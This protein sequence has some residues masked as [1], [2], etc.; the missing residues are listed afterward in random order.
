MLIIHRAIYE[1]VNGVGGI[2]APDVAPTVIT[3]AV[4][5]AVNIEGP[6]TASYNAAIQRWTAATTNGLYSN[7]TVYEAIWSVTLSGTTYQVTE[8]YEHNTPTAEDLTAITVASWTDTTA[9]LDHTPPADVTHYDRTRIEAVPQPSGETIVMYVSASGLVVIP[10]LEPGTQYRFVATSLNANG[11]AGLLDDGS[12]AGCV[13]AAPSSPEQGVWLNWYMDGS[14]SRH[15]FKFDPTSEQ[16]I[17]NGQRCESLG[18]GHSCVMELMT[19]D[20]VPVALRRV[21]VAVETDKP[22]PAGM[23]G[24]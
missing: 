4:G 15:S 8:Y 6:L 13:T 24:V 5:G 9:T 10:G 20:P 14:K 18:R 21:V 22:F 7:S 16:A 1:S 17:L 12:V 11:V 3:R 2:V 19:D 23:R